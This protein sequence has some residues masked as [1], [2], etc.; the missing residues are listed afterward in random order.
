[1]TETYNEVAFILGNKL[2]DLIRSVELANE[3][4]G[5]RYGECRIQIKVVHVYEGLK[6]IITELARIGVDEATLSDI[7][8]YLNH[9]G[10]NYGEIQRKI[11][12][13]NALNEEESGMIISKLKKR[14]KIQKK[15]QL[16]KKED[17][18]ETETKLKIWKDKI[19]I[20]LTRLSRE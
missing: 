11:D 4:A 7:S 18:M 8:S 14:I 15:N 2:G 13:D 5:S 10:K 16:L 19:I 3:T 6:Y 12:D 9:L 17:L 20:G 1:M